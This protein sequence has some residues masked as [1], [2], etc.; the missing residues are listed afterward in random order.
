MSLI[1]LHKLRQVAMDGNWKEIENFFNESAQLKQ[2]HIRVDLSN[3]ANP[4]VLIDQVSEIHQGG[5]GTEAVNGAVIALLVDLAIG[6][7]GI[8]HFAEG[9]TATSNL[10][11]NYVKPLIATKVIVKADRS[12]WQ[13]DFW[14]RAGDER[15]R[16]SMRVCNRFVGERDYYRLA[17]LNY[18]HTH[19]LPIPL[20]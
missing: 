4:I 3:P 9:M 1:H 19:I 10:N 13:T 12:N 20:S 6:L 7:L 2:M 5:I 18:W 15:E 11:I 16:R 14:D 8:Q 17:K